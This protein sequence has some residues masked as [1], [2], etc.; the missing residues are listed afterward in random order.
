MD[1]TASQLL[2][3]TRGL[4]E[5][6]R[7]EALKATGGVPDSA[8][9][10]SPFVMLGRTLEL[11]TAPAFYWRSSKRRSNVA[12]VKDSV[13]ACPPETA[14]KVATASTNLNVV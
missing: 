9:Q 1:R 8:Y 11:V 7:Q 2:E 5:E 13:L 12:L 10:V 3:K 14:C 4:L 6:R